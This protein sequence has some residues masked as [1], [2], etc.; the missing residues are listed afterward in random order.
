MRRKS[1]PNND[2]Q[3]LSALFTARG[4]R[5]RESKTVMPSSLADPVSTKFVCKRNTPIVVVHVFGAVCRSVITKGTKWN[6]MTYT[7]VHFKSTK[8]GSE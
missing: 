4:W 1:S 3:L 5:V 8:S 7:L 2:E 6:F